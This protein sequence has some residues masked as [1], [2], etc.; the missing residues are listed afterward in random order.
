MRYATL[1]FLGGFIALALVVPSPAQGIILYSFPYS[2]SSEDLYQSQW[3][4]TLGMSTGVFSFADYSTDVSTPITGFNWWGTYYEP[5][6]PVLS[7]FTFQ[8]WSYD[9][10][11]PGPGSI[12]YEQFLAGN[13]EPNYIETN[14][15]HNRDVYKYSLSLTTPFEP[16]LLETYY[17]SV[18]AYD[19]DN[20]YLSPRW[21][22]AAG[23][24]LA[25]GRDFTIIAPY[26]ESIYEDWWAHTSGH[27]GLAFEVISD[28]IP[29]PGT[30][31]L[32]GLGLLGA[33]SYRRNRPP[34][35]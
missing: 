15:Q 16:T 14:A 8:I 17:F 11:H 26:T 28:P 29:E 1:R 4:G 13:A 24:P 27:G 32:L 3:G 2:T 33:A 35:L 18:A 34:K 10:G 23:A 6:N 30:L 12:L 19:I 31:A 7:G 21:Y 5:V 25:P 22:W 20:A 9:P